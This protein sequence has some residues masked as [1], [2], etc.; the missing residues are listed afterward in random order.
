MFLQAYN[1]LMGNREQVIQVCE[2]M[3]SMVSDCSQMDTEIDALNEKI[4][5]VA[6]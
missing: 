6:E 3:R 2:V 5:V 1:Q 4:T